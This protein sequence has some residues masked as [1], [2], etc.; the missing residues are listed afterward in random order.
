MSSACM[1]LGW[2]RLEL[3]KCWAFL[4]QGSVCRFLGSFFLPAGKEARFNKKDSSCIDRWAMSRSA[5]PLPP[6]AQL[7]GCSVLYDPFYVWYV[8]SL[9]CYCQ[10]ETL[11]DRFRT[12]HS[13]H[14]CSSFTHHITNKKCMHLFLLVLISHSW[15][16][17]PNFVSQFQRQMGP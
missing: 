11:W 6:C 10:I 9:I 17:P 8:N 7:F 3:P 1:M 16:K 15:M 14:I 5:C 13:C 12:N 2:H 4:R